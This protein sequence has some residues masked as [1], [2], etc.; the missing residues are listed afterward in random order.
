MY[1]NNSGYMG[2][3]TSSRSAVCGAKVDKIGWQLQCQCVPQ[4]VCPALLGPNSDL[5]EPNPIRHPYTSLLEVAAEAIL[6]RSA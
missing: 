6:R 1:V 2:D 3:K 4:N 5:K